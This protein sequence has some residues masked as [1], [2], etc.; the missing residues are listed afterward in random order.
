[1]KLELN[2]ISEKY[3]ELFNCLK[4]CFCLHQSNVASSCKQALPQQQFLSAKLTSEQIA[5]FEVYLEMLHSWSRKIDLV[6]LVSIKD[7]AN[8]HILDSMAAAMVI[9]INITCFPCDGILDIGSGAGL[10]G[11]PLAILGTSEKII[12]CEPRQ[13]RVIFL[14]EVIRNLRLSNV[15]VVNSRVEDIKLE[16]LPSVKLFIERAIGNQRLLVEQSYRLTNKES[17]AVQMG[18]KNWQR[19]DFQY[20]RSV[21]FVCSIPY[22]LEI[23]N[24]NRQIAIWK[25]TKN[26]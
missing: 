3:T 19:Q 18:G 10:P 6:S 11:I 2:Y 22:S 14:K 16:F 8:R 23:L 4:R 13:R 24:A 7:M 5:Q 15:E 25:C 21:C 26:R 20:P 12:L 1:M 9:D 17:Y